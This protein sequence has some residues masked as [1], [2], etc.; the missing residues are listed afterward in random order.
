MSNANF[1]FVAPVSN[2]NFAKATTLPGAA[3]RITG[4]NAGAT[5]EPGEP[6]HA[7]QPGGKSIWYSW[8]P[9][10][11]GPETFTTFGSS[12]D[13]LLA[14]YTGTSV[15]ALTAVASNDDYGNTVTSSVTFLAQ[16]GTALPH[17][18]GWAERHERERG[19][20]L[21]EERL[22]ARHSTA[23]IPRRARSARPSRFPVPISPA[24][25]PSR[26]AETSLSYSV[27]SDAEIDAT[28]PAGATS[29]LLS[30]TNLLGTVNSP[31][32]SPSRLRR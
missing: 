25:P 28:V 16:A 23:S 30:V 1:V 27:V 24:P 6:D 31:S 10:S 18:G 4:N 7:G 14:V 5:K 3:A 29:G 2:D 20:E 26:S 8:T 15:A 32:P 11:T 17:R 9:A 12:F 19:A 21:V 22:P 13:T